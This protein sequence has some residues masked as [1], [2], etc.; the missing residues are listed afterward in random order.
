LKSKEIIW[1]KKHKNK[2]KLALIE[3]YTTTK[4]VKWLICLGEV[5]NLEKCKVEV[6]KLKSLKSWSWKVVEEVLQESNSKAL[7]LDSNL[8]QP[9]K[10]ISKMCTNHFI[11][12]KM[13][14]KIIFCFLSIFKKKGVILDL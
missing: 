11:T 9:K 10:C 8:Y 13:K 12:L 1:K 5:E 2:L 14:M 4:S 6:E 3:F 7:V